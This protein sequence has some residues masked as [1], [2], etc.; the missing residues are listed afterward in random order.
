M[1]NGERRAGNCESRLKAFRSNEDED[2]TEKNRS[3]SYANFQ[4]D[5]LGPI[6]RKLKGRIRYRLH[7]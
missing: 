5:L 1:I 3:E 4:C 6:D 7:A 2:P